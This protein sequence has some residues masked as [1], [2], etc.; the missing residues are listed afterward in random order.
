M[1]SGAVPR[2]T[3]DED[4]QQATHQAIVSG[5]A[6]VKMQQR[7]DG[8]EILS[9]LTMQMSSKVDLPVTD[10]LHLHTTSLHERELVHSVASVVS[11]RYV[12]ISTHLVKY[13]LSRR[14]S[15]VTSFIVPSLPHESGYDSSP[16][17]LQYSRT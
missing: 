8:G 2:Q 13:L 10:A 15:T 9:S 16:A 12:D 3:E 4:A 6:Y 17:S 5:D 11:V 7:T 14:D 1:A